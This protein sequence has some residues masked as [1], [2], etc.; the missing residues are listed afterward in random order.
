MP[1]SRK[2][3]RSKLEAAL[4]TGIKVGLI[5]WADLAVQLAQ[6]KAPV[7]TGRL[8]RSIHRNDPFETARLLWSIQYGT[9]VE[10]A[11]AHEFGSGIHAQDPAERHLIEIRPRTKQALAF[12]W[13]GGPQNYGFDPET[14]KH[15]FAR[16][17]HP[18]VPP[19][20]YLRP[21]ADESLDR[22]R[23][24][25]VTAVKAQLEKANA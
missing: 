24:L 8:A 22:G 10:Y 6:G 3:N 25:V 16:V 13:P 17:H 21:A 19:H 14:G 15:I 4:N 7:D 12:V 1:V 2:G 20:P 18:G 5:L 9:N 11:R 23:R